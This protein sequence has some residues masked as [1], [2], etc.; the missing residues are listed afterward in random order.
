MLFAISM[1]FVKVMLAVCILVALVVRAEAD[2]VSSVICV[3]SAFL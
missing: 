1:I 3:Q 2:F